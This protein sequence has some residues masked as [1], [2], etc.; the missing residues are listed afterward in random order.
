[1]S[2]ESSIKCPNCGEI[3]DV[4]EILYH[5]LENEFK[6]RNLNEIKSILTEQEYKEIIEQNTILTLTDEDDSEKLLGVKVDVG[7]E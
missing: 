5:Q 3:I 1:M 6:Q 2:T 4:N 7:Y